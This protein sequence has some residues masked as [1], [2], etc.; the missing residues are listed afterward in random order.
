MSLP[1]PLHRVGTRSLATECTMTVLPIATLNRIGRDE[2][3]FI[4]A[5][6]TSGLTPCYAEFLA[7]F[8]VKA[9]VVVPILQHYPSSEDHLW[10]LL[11]AH[12]CAA[13]RQWQPEEVQLLQQLSNQVGIAIQQAELYRTN[14][15]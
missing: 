12:Q 6:E 2:S 13:A 11:I 10:G 1:K 5:L 9:N 15:S 7:H 4:D 14:P 8:Q 3:R